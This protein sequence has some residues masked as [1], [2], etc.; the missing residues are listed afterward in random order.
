MLTTN[1]FDR[2]NLLVRRAQV[3]ASA[4]ARRGSQPRCSG[5]SPPSWACPGARWWQSPLS[6]YPVGRTQLALRRCT[7]ASATGSRTTWSPS[8]GDDSVPVAFA[9][10]FLRRPVWLR[11]QTNVRN[12]EMVR[13]YW[14]IIALEWAVYVLLS[15]MTTG[16]KNNYVYGTIE[17]II[18]PMN[19]WVHAQSMGP[20][21]NP[22][23][24]GSNCSSDQ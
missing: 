24:H 8:P 5:R 19:K 7:S 14:N 13:Y 3:L 16:L 23:V 11:K 4:P 15:S 12:C 21:M 1:L 18:G 20:S 17:L 9:C 2:C 10:M 22:I 6:A